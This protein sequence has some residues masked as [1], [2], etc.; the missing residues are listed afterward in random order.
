MISERQRSLILKCA[1]GNNVSAVSL[2]GSS[3][4][5]EAEPRDIDIDVKGL[6]PALFFNLLGELIQNRPR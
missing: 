4:G 3:I 5:T 2:F 6:R 1:A